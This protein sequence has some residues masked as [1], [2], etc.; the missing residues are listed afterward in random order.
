[1]KHIILGGLCLILLAACGC[2]SST[3]PKSPSLLPDDIKRGAEA[4]YLAHLRTF[5]AGTEKSTDEIP[6][7]YWA[8]GINALKPVKVYEHR[9]NIVVVQRVSGG[10]EEGKYIYISDSSYLPQ[11]GPD[12]FVLSPNPTSGNIY[13]LGDGVFD[14]KRTRTK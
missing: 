9:V 6:P 11:T 12:G 10:T 2:Q 5:N 13:T 3:T 7:A 1:M 14:F 4:T 8:D